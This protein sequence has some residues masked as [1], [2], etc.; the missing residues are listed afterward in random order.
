[1]F[2]NKK[3]LIIQTERLILRDF[4]QEDLDDFYEYSINPAVG[5]NAGWKPHE[6]KEESQKILD[7]FIN[8][9]EV[10]AIVD[11][12]SQK[13]IGSIGL[14]NDEKRSYTKARMVG[15]VLTEP[16]WGKGLMTEAVKAVIDYAFTKTDVDLLS[17]MHFP[18]NK[19]SRRVIEKCGF[20]YEGLLRK[21][22]IIFDGSVQDELCYSLLKE[23]WEKNV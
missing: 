15:Y 22:C 14:H 4:R 23:E 12:K 10:M 16:Y 19:R 6:N 17:I 1:M 5:P 3:E 7:S 13:V 20:R 8:G 9:N 11:K 18:F 2:I 21:S